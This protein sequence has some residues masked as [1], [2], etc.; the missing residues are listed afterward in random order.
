MSTKI[1]VARTDEPQLRPNAI[2]LAPGQP[3]F[4]YNEVEPGLFFK[5]RN[6]EL[7]KIGPVHVGSEAP[8]SAALGWQ[9]LSVGETWLDIGQGALPTFKIWSGKEWVIP[10]S[11][12]TLRGSLSAGEHLK[13]TS[14]DGFVSQTWDVIASSNNNPGQLVERDSNGDFAAGVITASLNGTATSATTAVTAT[15]ALTA[16]NATAADTAYSSTISDTANFCAASV[17]TGQGLTGG[18]ALTADRTIAIQLADDSLTVSDSGLSLNTGSSTLAFWGL[19]GGAASYPGKAVSEETLGSDA[20]NTLATKSYVDGKAAG[21]GFWAQNG[22]DI[23]SLGAGNVGIGEISPQEKLVV[24]GNVSVTGEIITSTAS[25]ASGKVEIKNSGRL[26]AKATGLHQFEAYLPNNDSIGLIVG[27]GEANETG[28][29]NKYA[30]TKDG[31]H[32]YG[33]QLQITNLANTSNI[34][35]NG[36]NGQAT[37]AGGIISGADPTNGANAGTQINWSGV[38][39]ATRASGNLLEGY[40]LNNT[41]A[42]TQIRADGSAAFAGELEL[43]TAADG[44]ILASP[45]GTRYRLTVTNSGALDIAAA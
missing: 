34:Q 3:V 28:L 1:Q 37:F 43:T 42:T 21:S 38:I 19:V 29:K 9:E 45:N 30:I 35:L 14:F 40:T 12:G 13:G 23:Y 10:A 33:D 16:I 18:G 8:N 6:N 36:S 44:V 15:T 39:R 22:S 2:Q 41:T 25:F 11:G 17:L 26:I 20:A 31:T 24:D 7:C 32:F 5:L 27:T 4:N